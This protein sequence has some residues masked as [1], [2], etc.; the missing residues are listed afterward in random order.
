MNRKKQFSIV[1]V[2]DDEKVCK[3]LSDLFTFHGYHVRT[4][5]NGQMALEV[6]NQSIPDLVIS[7]IQMPIMDGFT[8]FRVIKDRFPGVKY[9]LMTNYEIERHLALIREY[10]I[11]NI[12][13][14]G[15][16]LDFAEVVSYIRALLTGDIFGVKRYFPHTPISNETIVSYEQAKEISSRI[17]KECPGKNG[18]YLEV[19]VNELISNAVFHG[20]LQLT[21]IPREFWREDY[22]INSQESIKLTWARDDYKIGVSVE[23]PKGNL[24]K[25]DVLRWLDRF[26]VELG[27]NEQEHG[28]GFLIV[29]KLIDRFIVNI[30]PGK[31]TECII[32]QY[33]N[34]DYGSQK[35]PLLI[36]EL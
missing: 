27:E 21:G 19:A 22:E 18:F 3:L 28:R 31:R 1:V 25:G 8:L 14:K 4:A 29:R 9:I 30:D 16:D 23:D 11:G 35:K 26:N 5:L 32:I 24:K 15:G 10:N 12:I 17:A 2:D 36:H 33:F 7:D 20:V 13:V 6:I 34:R